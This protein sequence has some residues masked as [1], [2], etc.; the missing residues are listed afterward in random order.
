MN[1]EWW[2]AFFDATDWPY[3]TYPLAAQQEAESHQIALRLSDASQR[4]QVKQDPMHS[5][6]MSL[7]P[8]HYPVRKI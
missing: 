2:V 4:E 8:G 7:V 5:L 1:Q 6:T 3:D